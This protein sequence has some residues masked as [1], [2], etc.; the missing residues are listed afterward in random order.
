MEKQPVGLLL[1]FLL[2]R[3]SLILLNRSFLLFRPH[4]SPQC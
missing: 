2:P 1:A 4:R 3:Y